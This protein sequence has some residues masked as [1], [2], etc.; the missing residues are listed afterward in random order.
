MVKDK[1]GNGTAAKLWRLQSFDIALMFGNVADLIQE[2][3]TSDSLL[4][5]SAQVGGSVTSHTVVIVED[6]ETHENAAEAVTQPLRL[7]VF[8]GADLVENEGERVRGGEEESHSL[9]TPSNPGTEQLQQAKSS[10]TKGIR[11]I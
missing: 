2:G 11:L 3:V 9:R 6:A 5:K 4:D 8:V 10:K 1:V 7:V